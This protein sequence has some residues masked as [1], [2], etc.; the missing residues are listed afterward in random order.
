MIYLVRHGET[1]A[2]VE[3]QYLGRTDSPL[4][5]RGLAQHDGVVERLGEIRIDRLYCS[6]R[7]RCLDLGKKLEAAHGD[8]QLIVD[9]RIA[10]MDFGIFEG[11]SAAESQSNSPEAWQQWLKGDESYVI[12]DG[13]SVAAFSERVGSFAATLGAEIEDQNIVVVTHGGVITTLLCH[14]LNLEKT[15]K[16]RFYAENGTIVRLAVKDKYAY[17]LI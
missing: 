11:Q 1:Q 2:N 3:Q 9:D 10:E 13:E 17:L 7:A 5:R 15:D 16:W 12:P 8:I 14:F 4:T 6:P